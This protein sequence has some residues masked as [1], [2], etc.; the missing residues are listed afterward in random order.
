MRTVFR[1]NFVAVASEPPVEEE[2]ERPADTDLVAL[3][4]G[5]LTSNR[6][7]L[8]AHGSQERVLSSIMFE[9]FAQR[10]RQGSRLHKFH[11]LE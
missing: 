7:S 4:K 5:S 10:S 6:S 8:S 1:A 2:E 9:P 11:A 3:L